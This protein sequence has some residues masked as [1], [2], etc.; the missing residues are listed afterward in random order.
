VVVTSNPD[1]PFVRRLAAELLLFG[2]RVDV[3]ARAAAD[4]DLPQLLARSG[5]AALI[6]VDQG[7]QTAEVMVGESAAHG[8]ARSERERLDPRRRADTNAAVLAE[9]F[10][11]RLTE[12]GIAPHAA[13][14]EPPPAPPPVAVAPRPA[15]EPERRLWLAGAV[16]ASSGGLGVTPEAE[17]ELRAFP[18]R[19]LSTSAFGKLSLGSADVS[20]VEGTAQ[21]RLLAGGVL[22]DAYPI[23]ADS[24]ALKLGLGALLVS[25][26]MSG[27]AA[28]SAAAGRDVSVLVPAG[29]F[30]SGV[31]WR[32]SPRVSAELRGFVGACS[33]RIGVHF[34]GR[35]V[36]EY[37]Q[38]FFGGSL[39]VAVGVF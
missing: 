14:A 28:D 10:R 34:Q 33:P 15:P 3:Q 39:G 18:A 26:N 11:A 16:G 30:E 5:G 1:A 2:Y 4:D 29:M 38:P 13:A 36:A 32:V 8:P 7:S 27:Q 25:A 21:V 23:R 20:S 35:H 17:L 37:G 24:L 31:A 12:L 19:F 9:R 6:A 22:I